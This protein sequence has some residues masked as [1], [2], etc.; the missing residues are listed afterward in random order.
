[1]TPR[2]GGPGAERT[3]E[4]GASACIWT[5]VETVFRSPPSV[6]AFMTRALLPSPGLRDGRP[7]T[8]SARWVGHR[9][10][11]ERLAAL[12]A[13]TGLEAHD[14]ALLYP[15][16][17]GFRLTMAVVTHPAYPLPIWSALQIRN[18][19]VQHRP[20]APDERVDFVARVGDARVLEKGVEIDVLTAVEAD[21]ARAWESTTTFWYRGRHGSPQ[22]PS[23][24]AR[25][26]AVDGPEVASWTQPRTA[27]ALADLLGDY[28]GVH[29]FDGYAR[30]LGFPRAFAHPP[31]VL[32]RCL[33]ALSP[34]QRGPSQRLDAWLKGPVPYG[35]RANLRASARSDERTFAV[36]VDGDARPAIVGRWASAG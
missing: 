14:A 10:D 32:G 25:A 2:G 3:G 11:P 13:L 34:A 36:H 30:R 33:A 6:V 15:H 35:A 1:M 28:N 4:P 27:W 18:R 16:V 12:R 20:V 21:G 19:I 8:L 23:P 22:A 24:A 31:G 26:P 9:V 17:A 7:P 29:L 5:S